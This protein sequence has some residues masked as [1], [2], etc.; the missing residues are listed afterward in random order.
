M[1]DRIKIIRK[2][3]KLSQ[4][5]FGNRIGISRSSV[6]KLETGENNPS[7]RTLILICKEF[8]INEVWLRTGEG[9][10]ENMF[11]KVSEDDAYS[12]ALGKLTTEENRFVKNAV[13]YL[14]NTEPEKLKIIEEFMKSCLGIE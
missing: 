2:H 6:C 1:N 5:D 11:T 7:E 14:A 4:E 12:L 8:A 10:E 9:G 13:K 3:F